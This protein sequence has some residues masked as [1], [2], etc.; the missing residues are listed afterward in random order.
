MQE[1]WAQQEVGQAQL[2]HRA[3]TRRLVQLVEDLAAHPAESVPQACEEWAATKAAYRFWDNQHVEAAAIRRAHKEQTLT[4][5]QGQELILAIQDTTD[6]DYSTHAAT[7]GLGHLQGK[8]TQ[9][10]LPQGLKVPSVLA[11]SAQGVPLGLLYQQVWVREEETLPAPEQKHR[12]HQSIQEK[13]SGRCLL[14]PQAIQASFKPEQR[15]LTIADREADL[16][17]L[18]A[19]PRPVGQELLIRAK[20]DRRLKTPPKAEA[21]HLWEHIRQTPAAVIVAFEVPRSHEHQ[22]RRTTLAIHF[23]TLTIAPP[24]PKKNHAVWKPIPLQVVLAEEGD[25]PEGETAV[26]WLLLTT[27]PVSSGEEAVQVVLWYSLRWLIERYHYVLKSGCRIEELQ[28]E[29][30]QRLERALATYCIVAWRLLW[31]TYEA[32]EAPEASCEVL[33]QK[34]EW[35]ALYATRHQTPTPPEPPPTLHEAVSWI[36][37]LGGFLGRK[38]DGEPGVKGIWRGLRRLHDIAATWRLL[39]SLQPPTTF[40]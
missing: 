12:R 5:C 15:V 36:A 31:L 29:T 30:P 1:G 21:E 11:P 24:R 13:E 37:R 9:G 8:R 32:R 20:H 28:V 2:G 7:T 19:Q 25:P 38:S 40:G 6:V 14:A 27:M 34:D 35:Q 39:H 4:R 17:D 3:R 22:A 18:F 10:K 26:S 23:A 16:Y 33:L